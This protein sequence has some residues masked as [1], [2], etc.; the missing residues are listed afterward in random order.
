MEKGLIPKATMICSPSTWAYLQESIQL[1]TPLRAWKVLSGSFLRS[2]V[3][4]A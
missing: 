3:S 1:R 2:H 4:N